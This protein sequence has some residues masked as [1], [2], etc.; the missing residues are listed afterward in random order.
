MGAHGET[1]KRALSWVVDVWGVCKR[2]S[3]VASPGFESFCVGAG[4]YW[5]WMENRGSEAGGHSARGR[6][7]R[8]ERGLSST[9]VRSPK[10]A[11][12]PV[13]LT[14]AQ[15][16]VYSFMECWWTPMSWT[17]W[18]SARGQDG[19]VWKGKET[20]RSWWASRGTPWGP[21]RAGVL[22]LQC[23]R[24]GQTGKQCRLLE[25]GGHLGWLR[26]ERLS[27]EWGAQGGCWKMGRT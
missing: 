15:S 13:R 24:C 12:L 17:R 20:L 3:D 18:S 14:Q 7:P 22:N 4:Q 19:M 8:Q 9:W 26:K 5:W 1:D 23:E 16:L 2:P 11:V 27:G 10:D 6:H 25:K 21:V